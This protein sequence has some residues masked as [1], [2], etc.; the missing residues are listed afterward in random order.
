MLYKEHPQ[1]TPIALLSLLFDFGFLLVIMDC[2]RKLIEEV[3]GWLR[4]YD[5][6]LVDRTWTGPP[7]FK[8]LAEPVPPHREFLDGVAT[9]DVVIDKISGQNVRIYLPDTKSGSG[10]KE[11]LPVLLH[12]HGGGFCVTRPDWFIY[13][14]FYTR[15]TRTARVICISASLRLAPEN[16]LPAAVDDA[17]SALLWLRSVAK[18][19]TDPLAWLADHADFTRL[20]LIGDSSGGNIVHHVAARAG[21]QELAPLRLAGGI[22]LHPGFVR[23]R[24]S[25]SETENPESPFLTLEMVDKLLGLALPVGSNKDH[26]ITCPMGDA[27]PPLEEVRLPAILVCVA[28]K[29]LMVETQMEYYEAMKM[30]KKE[31]DVFVSKGM[32]H[33]FYLNAIA[34]DADVETAQQTHCLVAKIKDFIDTH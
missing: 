13:N 9:D 15:L 1:A 31:V 4:L 14:R 26:P 25:R 17:F 18:G 10:N 27:A 22:V 8:F 2:E 29:D 21:E 24:R 11:K 16:R 33:S 28:E 6:G 12:F 32:V 20:F 30:A 23:S 19:E 5:D 3:T 34:V 7:Q